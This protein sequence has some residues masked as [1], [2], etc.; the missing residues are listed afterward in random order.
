MIEWDRL[1]EPQSDGYDVEII[2]RLAEERWPGQISSG[3]LRVES[4][5]LD[6]APFLLPCP[7][8]DLRIERALG[9][10]R[11][12]RNGW[13]TVDRLGGTFHPLLHEPPLE[14]RGCICGHHHPPEGWSIYATVDDPFGAAEGIVHEAG[15]NRLH[16]M[17]IDLET[18]TGLI[19]AN[20]AVEL[21]E[22]PIRKDKLRPMSAV[23]QAQYSYVN[24]AQLDLICA[25]EG[26]EY[27]KVNLPRIEEG[28]E[29][30]KQNARWTP[31]GRLWATGF[32]DWTESVMEDARV[33]L[34][35]PA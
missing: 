32:F 6:I 17:G 28:Y 35:I 2:W 22:S 8:D 1:A 23:L 25:R 9:Y 11:S 33:V 26:W 3:D 30:I 5:D 18:H 16:A 20:D 21:Y 24:V 12:W 27:L 10:V 15:H 7:E 29:T 31:E 34:A 19:L 13:R 4:K 14:G